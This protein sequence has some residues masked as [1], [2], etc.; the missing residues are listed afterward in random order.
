VAGGLY[1][2]WQQQLLSRQAQ[3][4]EQAK[5]VK[6]LSELKADISRLTSGL[7]TARDDQ[8]RAVTEQLELE[9]ALN[10]L[11]TRIGQD[12]RDWTVA[13]AEYL[14]AIANRRL[15]LEQDVRT[16][17]AALEIA[18]ARLMYLADPAYHPVREQIAIELRALRAVPQADRQG[19]ALELSALASAVDSLS[20]PGAPKRSEIKSA[21]SG[22]REIN[23]WRSF[24]SAL[25]SDIKGLV[26]FRQGVDA[27]VPLLAPE[28][29]YFL[30]TNLRL[31]LESARLA[32]LQKESEVYRSALNDASAWLNTYFEP[33]DAATQGM[34][35]ALGRLQA[36]KIVT[37]LPD[38]STSLHTLRQLLKKQGRTA[39]PEKPEE[40]GQ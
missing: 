30:R 14:L 11:R 1:Y 35:E 40:N 9:A 19:L 6:R 28:Q 15:Q 32:L 3:N 21:A 29:Q 13:E 24:I 20:L 10:R 37:P 17:L 34:K 31:Q 5:T 38:I 33:G 18:D 7:Q 22:E 36:E 8:N 27:A 2:L 16:A 26:T 25:W 12:R 23:D 39:G 4:T